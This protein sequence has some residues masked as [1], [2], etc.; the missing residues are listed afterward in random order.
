MRVVSYPRGF[1]E[2][3]LGKFSQLIDS[4]Q[5]AE[6]PY[7]NAEDDYLTGRK[8]VPVTSCGAAIFALLAYQKYEM[9]KTHLV[10]QSNTMRGVYTVAR[11]LDFEVIVCDCSKMPGF[12]AMDPECYS[13]T[14]SDLTKR[15][16]LHQVVTIYSVIG[17]YLS[18]A[19]AEIETI[20][21]NHD[22]PFIVDMAHAHYLDSI[23]HSDYNHLAFS[24]Y[25]TKVLPVG[26]G[27]L[28]STKNINMFKWIKEFLIYD[29]FNYSQEYGLNLRA[30]EL[31]ACFIHEF[32]TNRNW[33]PFFKDRRIHIAKTYREICEDNDIQYMDFEEAE[34]YN[35]YK[36][37]VFDEYESVVE[38]NTLLT[39][40]KPTS[41]V[42]AENIIDKKPV[43]PH[44]CPPTYSD[45]YDSFVEKKLS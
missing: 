44:W 9:G 11:L 34:D 32:M 24:F 7:Y 5:V 41:P 40:F 15:G 43:L 38:K 26:E 35:A 21:K 28:I 4:G 2:K 42:F 29:R 45:L 39:R 13:E 37:V 19:F 8:S 12:L 1:K 23:I 6:G 36:F 14:L 27:G 33:R 31:T 30:N 20:S 17:G 16:L 10:L 3:L 22:I 25:A 18:T